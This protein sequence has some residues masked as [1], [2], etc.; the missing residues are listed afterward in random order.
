MN[1]LDPEK[2]IN[3]LHLTKEYVFDYLDTHSVKEFRQLYNLPQSKYTCIINY[4]GGYKVS[5]EKRAEISRKNGEKAKYAV[6]SQ[7]AMQKITRGYETLD[8]VLERLDAKQFITDWHNL[9]TKKEL[10]DKYNLTWKMV[11]KLYAH[12]NLD[13]NEIVCDMNH[14]LRSNPESKDR[15]K[16]SYIR[17]MREKYGVDNYSQTDEFKEKYTNKM[18]ENYGVDCYFQSKEFRNNTVYYNRYM[19]DNVM[20]DSS[21]ELVFYIYAIEHGLSIIREPLRLE[22]TTDDYMKHYYYPDFICDGVLIEIKGEHLLDENKKLK[23]C[24]K[25]QDQYI[26]DAKQKC[27]EDNN[28]MIL[29]RNDIDFAF[30]YFNK[31]GYKLEDYKRYE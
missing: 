31:K 26:L 5:K 24:Y 22:Y 9:M 29:S 17:K 25:D 20:F 6:Y 30:E 28:V 2:I 16:A 13:Y 7:E 8:H 15:Q 10:A 1:K 12:F 23:K 21:Y 19:Y 14:K 27:I 18:Q 11:D 3:E 4:F